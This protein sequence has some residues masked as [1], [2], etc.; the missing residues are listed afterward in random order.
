[1]K[2]L[3]KLLLFIAL[4]ITLTGCDIK[5]DTMEDI[6]IYLNSNSEM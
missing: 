1:M 6:E 5:N 4:S 2:Y 3:K